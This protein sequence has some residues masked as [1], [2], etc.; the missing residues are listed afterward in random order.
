TE[1]A[2]LQSEAKKMR[3][4]ASILTIRK[5]I[6]TTANSICTLIGCTPMEIERL[7]L[8]EQKMPEL[9]ES[10]PLEAVAIRPDV[11]KSEMA[12]A[13][14]FYATNAARSDFYPSVKLSGSA[15]WMTDGTSIADPMSFIWKAAGSLLQPVFRNGANKAALEVAK[16]RQEE[17]LQSFRQCLLEAGKEVNDALVVCQEAGGRLE[18]DRQRVETLN[19]AVA[20]IQLLMNHST[21]NYLEVLTAQQSLLDAE[22]DVVNDIV[23]LDASIVSLYHSLGGGIM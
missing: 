11:L 4:E 3:L 18:I 9:L 1:V 12:L 13:Q 2:V 22:L 10:I 14:A 5:N 19:D 7:P 8:A 15:G 23:S 17:A 6:V 20:K 16:A 21:T